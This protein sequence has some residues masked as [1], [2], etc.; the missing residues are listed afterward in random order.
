MGDTSC[1]STRLGNLL[2]ARTLILL[3]VLAA[4]GCWWVLEQPSSSLME[5]HVLFQRFLAL[6]RVRRL[7]ICM[8]DYGSPTLKPTYLYSS[9]HAIDMLPDYQTT[10]RLVDMEMVRRY[11]NHAGE[12]RICG[13]RDLKASQA[14]PKGFGVAL[15]KCRTAV[16]KNH[17][18]MAKRF[19]KAA[20]ASTNKASAKTPKT[21][22]VPA[23]SKDKKEKPG[24]AKSG[25]PSSAP[26]GRSKLDQTLKAEAEAAARAQLRAIKA[27]RK[28]KEQKE[29][30]E[31]K[32]E[33]EPRKSALRKPDARKEDGAKKGASGKDK[34]E[35]RE[36][37]EKKKT[38]KVPKQERK[39]EK[40]DEKD[41]SGERKKK[42]A[43]KSKESGQTEDKGTKEAKN[44]KEVDQ[45]GVKEKKTARKEKEVDQTEVKEKKVARKEKEV[46]QT[47]VKEKKVARKEK[48]VDQTG[49][50]EKKETK[51]ENE[52]KTGKAE[53][54]KKK[55]PKKATKKKSKKE[56]NKEE[57]EEGE[58]KDKKDKEKPIKFVPVVKSKVEHVF[59]T[60]ETKKGLSTPPAPEPSESRMSSP[61][62]SLPSTTTAS[63]NLKKLQDMLE[64][65]DE[66]DTSSSDGE[67]PK[68]DEG[69]EESEE[70][71]ES[72][73]EDRSENE[74]EEG[75]E[76][77]GD[78]TAMEAEVSPSEEDEKEDEDDE[79]M[80][81]EQQED[82]SDEEED[83]EEEDG[84]DS[85]SSGGEEEEDAEKDK[86][87]EK[88][89]DE[90][91]CAKKKAKP[92]AKEASE[93]VVPVTTEDK[94]KASLRDT[95]KEAGVARTAAVTLAG[96]DYAEHLSDAIKKHYQ[97]IETLYSNVQKT[98]KG[99]PSEK[100][101]KDILKKVE[102]KA[103][104]TKKFQAAANAFLANP[105]KG[106]GES[107]TV[108]K[109]QR[110]ETSES[111]AK[112]VNET[113]AKL[114]SW[115]IKWAMEGVMPDVG[116]EGEPLTGHRLAMK[117][118]PMAF[119]W[120]A[121]YYAM[122]ADLKA[123][124]WLHG[125][126][127]YYKAGW[128]CDSCLAQSGTKCDPRMHYKNFGDSKAW[129][130]TAISH[131]MYMAMPGQLSPWSVVPGWTLESTTFDFMHNL[132]LG[133]GRDLIGST[134]KTLIRRGAYSHL[135]FTDMDSILGFLQEEMVNDC[136]QSGL[137][138]PR[139]PT[140]TETSLSDKDY[141]ELST[142]FKAC[143]IKIMVF[144]VA[145][146]TQEVADGNPQDIVLQVL[147]TCCYSLQKVVTLLDSSGI[148]LDG[149]T[150]REASDMLFL[151]I[152]SYAW[153]AAYFYNERVM[154]F[155]IRPKLHYI[156]H[157][158]IQLRE[159]RI[160]IGVFATFH[161][162]TF[163]GKIKAVATACHGKTMT[164]R[165]YER[166]LLCL[167][168][169]VHQ[170]QQLENSNS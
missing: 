65:S 132:Y 96:L 119:G 157:Q 118:K 23:K 90:A 43:K 24:I 131:K 148:I 70:E 134:F 103:Q 144:W 80:N 98:L 151:H 147:A 95:L 125:F 76:G 93:E 35:K 75:A 139:K 56:K 142:K 28:K 81:E 30:K 8:A 13:G 166:Y 33:K 138:L 60:P 82:E 58:K 38:E 73:G 159:W 74:D 5:Y 109:R 53:E 9:H 92:V 63:A 6:I 52:G 48:E 69:E 136:A 145:K 135:P 106:K 66:D 112:Q 124:R 64:E 10:R 83:E 162:E 169:L 158:A 46:D 25:K 40:N 120:R 129:P 156:Y 19:L 26:S 115:S 108:R 14:Y 47:E 102:E 7:S 84:E 39:K 110:L 123:R 3:W 67:E 72:M 99:K 15:A 36:A 137:Y 122:K 50:N 27:A 153:L 164:H 167:A 21:M 54:N 20:R 161:D 114:A 51:K 85:D 88:T 150:A 133:T 152:K 55:E 16:Q 49:V 87:E 17:L 100:D 130:L 168:L 31:E 42:E 107:S 45:T 163:L 12:S 71:D 18:K 128:M 86:I 121:C 29:E 32:K 104:A 91:P 59:E 149:D 170:H 101:L 126:G 89:T 127:R 146:K 11:T 94:L 34:K 117:G 78:E 140:L 22:P 41:E 2:T 105:K 61:V 97:D 1:R 44:E 113:A 116:F 37:K 77:N 4:K 111:V 68:G 141:C 160:N 57:K 143:H 165:V 79:S 62:L 154:V 155:R